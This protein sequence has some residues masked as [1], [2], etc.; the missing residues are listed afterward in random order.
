M[1]DIGSAV[2]SELYPPRCSNPLQLTALRAMQYLNTRVYCDSDMPGLKALYLLAYK[3]KMP[4]D[5]YV[6]RDYS[7]IDMYLR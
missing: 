4:S 2:F 6:T 1:P 3:L 7:R 5:T